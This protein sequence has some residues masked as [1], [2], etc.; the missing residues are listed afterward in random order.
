MVVVKVYWEGVWCLRHSCIDVN[1]MIYFE[2]RL[3]CKS[4]RWRIDGMSYTMWK[5]REAG[6]RREINDMPGFWRI[7]EFCEWDILVV[8]DP[9]RACNGS[10]PGSYVGY[11]VT[12][13]VLDAGGEDILLAIPEGAGALSMQGPCQHEYYGRSQASVVAHCAGWTAGVRLIS[14]PKPHASLLTVR[15]QA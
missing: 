10:Y 6:S 15:S 12:T 3:G 8:V 5:L 7:L 13:A 14:Q 4:D 1:M 11:F 2:G 9:M